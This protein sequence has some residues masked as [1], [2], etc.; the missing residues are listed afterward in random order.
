MRALVMTRYGRNDVVELRELAEPVPGPHD[1][2]ID[3]HA[4]ALNPIDYKIRLGQ[5]RLIRKL[6]FPAVLGNELAG[7]VVAKGA[8]V[9]RV[10]VGDEVYARV[11]KDRLGAFAE[12]AVVSEG[13]VAKKPRTLSM[14]EAAAVPLAALTALQALREELGVGPGYRLL[15]PAGAGGVGTFAIQIAKHLGAQVTTTASSA[16]RELVKRLGADTVIDYRNERF[17]DRLRDL[18]GVFDT[19]GGDELTRQFSVVRRG[20]RICS[21]AGVPEPGTADR[22]GASGLIKA[23]FWLISA[24]TRRRAA[25]SGVR[26]TYL[27]MRPDGAQLDELAALID[28]GKLRVVLDRVFPFAQGADALAYLEAG[29]AKGK[30]V[31]AMKA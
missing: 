17:E 23:V 24:A 5:L 10:A 2:L 18:D 7:V 22:I 29:R 9:T 27:F 21:I 16:G 11:D 4:A 30:V 13:C 20:G 1:V 15:I 19:L 31:L 12:R 28:G 25:R 3:V 14:T 6:R 26:Y 8:A